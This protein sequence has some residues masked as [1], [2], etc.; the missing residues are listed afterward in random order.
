MTGPRIESTRIRTHPQVYQW[1]EVV[2]RYGF[3]CA[4][5][6]GD[7]Y[8][9]GAR[10]Q[11]DGRL[12]CRNCEP[13]PLR[14][15]GEA[16]EWCPGCQS[17]R[18]ATEFTPDALPPTDNTDIVKFRAVLGAGTRP[19]LLC[20]ACRHA[21]RPDEARTCDHCAETFTSSRSDARYCSGRCRTAAH[22]AGRG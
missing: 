9:R 2:E 11:P 12:T 16:V 21:S 17:A 22:R 15:A 20:A 7:F 18:P 19:T 5:C 1:A 14:R 4:D 6:G 10:V 3:A 13:T 8:L